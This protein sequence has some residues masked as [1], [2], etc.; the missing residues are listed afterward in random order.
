LIG[1]ISANGRPISLKMRISR[2]AN[3][4]KSAPKRSDK[5]FL[6]TF[7][8]RV[9]VRQGIVRDFTLVFI[10]QPSSCRLWISSL[11][12]ILPQNCF[13]KYKSFTSVILEPSSKLQR[14][15]QFAFELSGL[16]TIIVLASVE[17]LCKFC[18]PVAHHLY[19]LQLNLPRNCN[20]S[21]KLH[22]DGPI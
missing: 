16:S 3:K 12:S 17:V 5:E 4:G 6:T 1:N 8:R 7:P 22:L 2:A 10:D 21:K 18:F 11:I 15:K 13:S 20:E 19:L 9:T 14:I